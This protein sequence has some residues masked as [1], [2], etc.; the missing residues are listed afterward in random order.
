MARFF[1]LVQN[2]YIKIFHRVS[3]WMILGIII[4]GAI[5]LNVTSVMAQSNRYSR[6]QS[7]DFS[8]EQ[9]EKLISSAKESKQE[10]YE[11]DVEMLEFLRD[12][13]IS[14]SD[15][16]AA[17][18]NEITSMKKQLAD[19]KKS[20]L[21]DK[22]AAAL[23][24]T[25]Q[26]FKD[27]I[28]ADNWETYY[29]LK[30]SQ[31]DVNTSLSK[32]AKDV[33]KWQ[34]QYALD[35]AVKPDATNWKSSLVRE[36]ARLKTV[37]FES[38]QQQQKGIQAESAELDKNKDMILIDEYRLEHD[39]SLDVASSNLTSFNEK[40]N[41]WSVLN[42]SYTMYPMISLLIIV[43][44]GT[45][46]ASEFSSGTIKFL[47]I[48]PIRRGKIIGSKYFM[49]FT[50]SYILL[51][52]F[53]I[54]LAVSTAFFFDP[55]CISIP[56]LYVSNGAVQSMSGFAHVAWLYLLSSVDIV[57]TATLAFAISSLFR[58]SALA[59]GIGVFAMLG[60]NG[61]IFF[62]KDTLQ[63]DWARY[64]IFA[65]TNFVKIIDGTTSFAHQSVTVA[66]IIV[67]I[68]MV[69]FLLTAWDGF[70]RREV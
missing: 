9:Y 16:R 41:Y 8:E 14:Y 7:T 28:L 49:I 18:G 31:I 50:L 44:A 20:G 37:V 21:D 43:V 23:T 48:N 58:S 51:F 26:D 33:Q 13:K 66:L 22:S 6:T 24:K 30:I 67:A 39:I 4:V 3:T 38:Q 40:M 63:M 12:N 46:I 15:W 1:R 29:K 64:L 54:I 57:V 17:A 25:A 45:S 59:I 11:L 5:G 27:A 70:V 47:L 2:E 52:L 61:L 53:Y 65:N 68:H 10:G 36:T 62:L 32:E 19:P 42:T 69:V 55:R 35:H 34:Y 60:G 56:Y